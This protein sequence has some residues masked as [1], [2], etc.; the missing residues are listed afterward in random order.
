MAEEVWLRGPLEGYAAELQP[1]A[2]AL[3]QAREDLHGLLQAVE[4][5]RLWRAPGSAAAVAW[6]VRH[7]AGSLDRLLTYARGE[8]LSDGQVAALKAERTPDPQM[9]A[10]QLL[11]IADAHID[12]ALAQVRDT[13]VASLGEARGVG[14]KQLPS[15]VRGLL[16]HA[17]EHTTRHVGQISTTL[18]II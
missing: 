8:A 18:K 17:A 7:L 14:R 11:E 12:A 13:P 16:F 4:T 9:G 3:V 5:E 1:V 6:H 2:H 10:A 15:T